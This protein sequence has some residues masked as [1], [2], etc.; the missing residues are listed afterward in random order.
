MEQIYCGHVRFITLLFYITHYINMHNIYNL[1]IAYIYT[2]VLRF[3][4]NII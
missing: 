4:Y 2:E 1:I 3:L